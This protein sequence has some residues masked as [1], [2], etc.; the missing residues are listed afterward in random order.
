MT[1]GFGFCIL[2]I[3]VFFLGHAGPKGQKGKRDTLAGLGQCSLEIS[4]GFLFSG[5]SM[6]P[7]AQSGGYEGEGNEFGIPAWGYK[8]GA[9]QISLTVQMGEGGLSHHLGLRKGATMFP[10]SPVDRMYPTKSQHKGALATTK[11]KS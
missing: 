11:P 5:P 7:G 9:H 10:H 3:F 6:C 8:Q 4:Q 1:I 2:R